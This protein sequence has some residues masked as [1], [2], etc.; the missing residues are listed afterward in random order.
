MP[1]SLKNVLAE[2]VKIIGFVKSHPSSRPLFS[3]S[4]GEMAGTHKTLLL[5][6]R[7]GWLSPGGALRSGVQPPFHGAPFVRARTEGYSF[8][9]WFLGG[10]FSKMNELSLEESN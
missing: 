6:P 7:A 4:C 1:A 5:H 2:A 8:Q 9:T 3:L 10:V